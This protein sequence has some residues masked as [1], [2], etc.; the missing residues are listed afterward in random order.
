MK[1]ILTLLTLSVLF[2][3]CDSKKG[4]FL[5]T[6]ESQNSQEVSVD[7]LKKLITQEKLTLFETIDHKANATA[8][9]MDGSRFWQS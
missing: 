3:G 7:K 2:L 8:V 6:I 5:E 1:K 9:N 4:T